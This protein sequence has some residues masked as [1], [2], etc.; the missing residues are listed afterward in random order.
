MDVEY[1]MR[2]M[3][4]MED[5]FRHWNVEVVEYSR[6]KYISRQEVCERRRIMMSRV[7][8]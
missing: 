3:E 1:N 8:F 5:Y 7:L 4:L 6:R 2:M